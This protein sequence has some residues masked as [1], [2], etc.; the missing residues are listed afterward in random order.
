M[1]IITYRLLLIAILA[2]FLSPTNVMA[3]QT[4][5]TEPEKKLQLLFYSNNTPSHFIV[6]EKRNQKLKL[7]EQKD[8]LKLLKEFTCATGENPGPKKSSGDARTPEGIYHIT[9]VYEDKRITVFGSRAFHLDYPN[10]FDVQAGHLGDGI[11][12]HGTNKKLIPNS[13][14]G[15]ITLKNSD[16]DELAPYLVVNTTPIIVLD[17]ESEFM[18]ESNYMLEKTSV[19]FLDTLEKF[20]FNTEKDPTENIKTLS[21]IKLGE[22]LIISIS[23]VLS[24]DKLTQYTEHKRSFLTQS[25]NGNW[26]TLFAVQHQDSSPRILA[27]HPIKKNERTEKTSDPSAIPSAPSQKP[28]ND[29]AKPIAPTTKANNLLTKNNSVPAKNTHPANAKSLPDKGDEL[30]SFIERWRNAWV[31]KDI[32]A[33]MNCYSSSFRSGNLNRDEWRAKKSYLN[34]KYNYINVSI[35]NI[36][37]EWTT[38]GANVTFQQ[39][40]KSDQLQN[41]GTK[42][43]QLVNKKNHWLIENELI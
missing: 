33:Y 39:T 25:S 18:L 3:T 22:Q 6:V 9:E 35:R 43:L 34:K 30:L 15:C 29:L 38:T 28:N 13:T 37:I 4:S 8:N 16:L 19:R 2:L 11:F 32:E 40:Y 41:N 23:Y 10:A 36:V 24:D 21:Y 12:I 7:F 27:F 5:T 1:K 31:T 17:A 20:S 14:N 42:T 26:R